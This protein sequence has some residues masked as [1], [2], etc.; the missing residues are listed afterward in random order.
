[1]K[2]AARLRRRRHDPGE[3]AP[4]FAALG[5]PVRLRIVARLCDNGPL[6]VVRLA[7]D[8]GVSRQAISK[9]L[10]TLAGA[11]LVQGERRGREHVWRLRPAR[12]DEARR[13]LGAIGTRW[14]EAL[15]RL[16]AMVEG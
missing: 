7:E 5:D 14:D 12:L 2:S 10:E 1:M 11:G 8:S 16:Q 9:H 6:P 3:A 13:Q 15:A 4:V